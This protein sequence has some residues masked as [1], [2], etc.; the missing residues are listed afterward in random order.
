MLFTSRSAEAPVAGP[1]LTAFRGS[2]SS[3]LS[4]EQL[5]AFWN[6]LRAQAD[7]GWYVYAIGLPV[8]NAPRGATEVEKF[9]AAVDALLRQEHHED[10]CG[11]V[12]VDHKE[13]PTFIKIFD[14]NF[15][16][17]S[18]GTSKNPPAP[19]WVLSLLPPQ[20]LD[21]KRP[22]PASRARWWDELWR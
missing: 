22:L 10:Y 7:A 2:F 11:I 15:L 9:I 19:G 12:Y 14:P 13:T 21:A 8:P 3:L 17:S 20:P 4:W 1:F 18:C 6:V 5:D 16:G